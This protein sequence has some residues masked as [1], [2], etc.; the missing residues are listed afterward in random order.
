MDGCKGL[1]LHMCMYPWHRSCDASARAVGQR[2]KIH[3]SFYLT[4]N[5][6]PPLKD[7]PKCLFGPEHKTYGVGLNASPPSAVQK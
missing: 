1:A 5:S 4:C 6:S 3:L 2:M 7:N